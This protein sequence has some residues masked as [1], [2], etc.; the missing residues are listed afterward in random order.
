MF[1]AGIMLILLSFLPWLALP[2]VPWLIK[3]PAEQARAAGFLVLLGELLFWPGLALSGKETW[4][5]AKTG[6][7]RGALPELLRRLRQG[8]PH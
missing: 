7:W 8:R 6:G 3:G 2:A 1:R 4:S 5:A